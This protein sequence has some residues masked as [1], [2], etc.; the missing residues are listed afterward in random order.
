MDM[1]VILR[2]TMA[3]EVYVGT[4][5]MNVLMEMPSFPDKLHAQQG[6]QH[7][8]H[9]SHDG[10]SCQ[11]E[12][13]RNGDAEHEDHCAHEQEYGGMA[14]SPAETDQARCTPGRPLGKHCRDGGNMIRVQGM[15]QPE[16]EA[17]TQNCKQ[18]TI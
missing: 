1:A 8:E 16:D 14:Y 4:S 13:L 9:K 17:K 5:V 18:F 3:V 11:R 10:F 7:D 15:T 2:M 6:A 12:R